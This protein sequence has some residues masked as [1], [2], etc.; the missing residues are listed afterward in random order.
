MIHCGVSHLAKG[1]VL[2][3][4]AF[5]SGYQK[6]DVNGCV[7]NCKEMCQDNLNNECVESKINLGKV[8]DKINK[9]FE[10][11]IIDLPSV[12]SCDAGRWNLIIFNN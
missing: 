7:P 3:S 2:E 9:Y 4:C 10:E 12:V 1:L 5:G 6:I 11:K 8:C